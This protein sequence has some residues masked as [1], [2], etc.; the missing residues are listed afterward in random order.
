MSPIDTHWSAIGA[1]W[2]SIGAVIIAVSATVIN[3]LFFRSQVDPHV[4]VYATSDEKRPGVII[5]VIENV[6]KSMAR[7][8]TFKFSKPLPMKAFGINEAGAAQPKEMNAGPLITG[9][10]ALGPGA[11]RIIVWGQFGG[12]HKA[13]GDKSIDISVH[14]K[15]ESNFPFSP[16][17]LCVVCPIDVKSFEYTDASDHNWDKKA[18][19]QLERIADK[20]EKGIKIG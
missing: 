9:I 12:L 4:I 20:L 10:P 17:K 19:E 15:R 5:L 18:V 11:K 2:A 16:K 8:V 7:D 6:G 13:L 3:Y 14:F 1:F